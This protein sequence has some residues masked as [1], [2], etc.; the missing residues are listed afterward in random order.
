[1][2]V[3]QCVS[4]IRII[5]LIMIMLGLALATANWIMQI[6]T[7]SLQESV[8]LGGFSDS[9]LDYQR[10]QRFVLLGYISVSLWGFLLAALS[11][12]IGSSIATEKSV[13]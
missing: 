3:N 7:A 4:I 6:G 12:S 1:M 8:A 10:A 2:T 11:R 9:F 13:R 5:A